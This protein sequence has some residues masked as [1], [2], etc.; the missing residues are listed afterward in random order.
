MKIEQGFIYKQICD[1]M[2]A[3]TDKLDMLVEKELRD[4]QLRFKSFEKGNDIA[5][6][7]VHEENCLNKDDVCLAEIEHHCTHI[8]E[9]PCAT[10][11]TQDI[12]FM[13]KRDNML[14]E[15]EHVNKCTENRMKGNDMC[16]MIL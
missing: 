8:V 3:T 2:K 5:D 6:I 13:D 15:N 12:E 9:V 11:L 7:L 4:R 10:N 14:E 16:S 1:L